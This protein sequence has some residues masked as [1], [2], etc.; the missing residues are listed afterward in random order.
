MNKKFL[1]VFVCLLSM[2]CVL[3]CA[4]NPATEQIVP[5]QVVL[6]KFS[7]QVKEAKSVT[8]TILVKDSDGME[9]SGGMVVIDFASK[10]RTVTIRTPNTEFTADGNAW[11]TEN[12]IS[13]F[14]PN[15]VSFGWQVKD[16]TSL[17]YNAQSN[18]CDGVIDGDMVEQLGLADIVSSAQST[19]KVKLLVTGNVDEIVT[20]NSAELSYVSSAN[21]T[22]VITLTTK[23][24]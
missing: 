24:K 1:M 8:A 14:D 11:K 10:Q 5:E 23:A 2:C 12:S 19:V 6:D 20:V 21:N 17:T 15:T 4:C 3:L 16:F 7:A 9:V 22:V 13:D 18:S